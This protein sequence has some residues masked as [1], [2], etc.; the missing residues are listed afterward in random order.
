MVGDIGLRKIHI[1]N[2]LGGDGHAV[3]DAID[4]SGIKLKL[5]GIPVNGLELNLNTHA[6][7]Y[8]LGKV[9]IKTDDLVL[10]VA[11]S[12]RGVAVVKADDEL[13]LGFD[14]LQRLVVCRSCTFFEKS[15]IL[16]QRVGAKPL[17]RNLSGGAVGN[18]FIHI[19]LHFKAKGDILIAEAYAVLFGTEIFGQFHIGFCCGGGG[20]SG[21]RLR[22]SR[23]R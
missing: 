7:G 8:F 3:P 20:R 2:A 22:G 11:E 1:L 5:L 15:L 18:H 16:K 19:F 12:H 13:A 23:H 6:L 4:L 10:V 17:L 21:R 14:G 9:D